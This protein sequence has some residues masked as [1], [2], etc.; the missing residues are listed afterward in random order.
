MNTKMSAVLAASLFTVAAHAGIINVT[1]NG[2]PG[3]LQ[4]AIASA[5]DGDV[6]KV[7]PGVYSPISRGDGAAITIEST[8]GAEV[9]IID[10]GNVSRCAYLGSESN[11]RDTVLTG[12]TLRNGFGGGGAGVMA[13]TLNHCVLT[14]NTTTTSG[15]GACFSDLNHCVLVG[16]HADINGGATYSGKIK[17]CLVVGNTAG[18]NC[19]GVY[20]AELA[21]NCTIV[22][23]KGTWGSGGV[24]GGTLVNCIVWGNTLMDDTLS[25]Y[26]LYYD[27]TWS[28]C[29]TTPTR[30]GTNI[31][32]DDPLFADP[33]NGDYRLTKPSLC[34]DAGDDGV[35]PQGA[36]DLDGNDRIQ[37]VHVDL[38]CYEFD[39]ASPDFWYVDIT[40]PDDNGSGRRW[41][42]AKKNISAALALAS[43]GA[44]ILVADGT[45]APINSNNKAVTIRSVNGADK[46]FIDGGG[47]ACCAILGANRDHVSTVLEGF[48]LTNGRYG[49]GGGVRAG[50]LNRCILTGNY[51]TTS[52]GGAAYSTLNNCLVVDNNASDGGGAAFATLNNCT[53]VKNHA[54]DYGGGVKGND[55]ASSTGGPAIINNSIVWGNTSGTPGYESYEWALEANYSCF[56]GANP[57]GGDTYIGDNPRFADFAD[58]DYRL[59]ADS[60][61]INA[62]RNS[63]LLIKSASDLDGKPRTIG[64][65]VDMGAYEWGDP[66]MEGDFWYV[67]IARPNDSGDGKSWGAAKK[68]ISSAITLA[69]DGDTLLVADGTYTP[70]SS[71]GKRILIHSVNG[72]AKTLIDA[73]GGDRCAMLGGAS[74]TDTILTG[75]TLTGGDTGGFGGGSY[76]GTLND[77][78]ISNNVATSGGGGAYSGILNRCLIT[79]NEASANGGGACES[80]LTHCTI[81]SNRV[82]GTS[83]SSSVGGGAGWGTLSHCVVEGNTAYIGG[84]VYGNGV[85]DNC[86]IV[87]NHASQGGGAVAGILNNCTIVKN[88]ASS[89]AGMRSS[90][91]TNCVLWEN[92]QTNGTLD[93]HGNATLNYSCSSPD[94]GGTNIHATDPLFA[95]PAHGDYRLAPHSP[96]VDAGDNSIATWAFDLDGN[97]R[98]LHGGHSLTV[99]MGCYEF[100]LLPAPPGPTSLVVTDITLGAAIGGNIPV[101]L[102]FTYEG[103]LDPAA[104]TARVWHDL[105][106]AGTPTTPDDFGDDGEGHA[107]LLLLIPA[108]ETKAFFRIESTPY[109]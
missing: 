58:G 65:T 7:G 76:A 89:F 3:A 1:H 66:A 68:Q 81:S 107:W 35:V 34:R 71:S 57:S 30:N 82:L 26:Y 9:T 11:Y 73:K 93:N 103:T 53:V 69:S 51:A 21:Y 36:L 25:N 41:D 86:L 80:T 20:S 44:T 17:N 99:D 109:R 83:T 95:D 77:C 6:I 48:T 52:G 5:S 67:D 42:S 63:L 45:Y 27:G 43:G 74:S 23:N 61:C 10:G 94:P 50:M 33:E 62:G 91:A 32:T 46:T 84:G 55:S 39:P 13:G 28:H 4:A 59:R 92:R 16:N 47:S 85:R 24:Y 108:T 37:G 96:C 40:R 15:G 106:D 104:I 79:D 100:V 14:N 22:G 90:T 101:T 75:F 31:T 19:G 2:N 102:A 12:F 88:T 70:I 18:F 60:P 54:R 72:A 87:G 105:T 98:I 56:E 97:P 38:G 78:V 49:N 64:K 29:C 8:D